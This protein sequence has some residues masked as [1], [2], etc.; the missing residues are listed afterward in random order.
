M[1]KFI[2]HIIN[3]FGYDIINVNKEIKNVNF[4]DLL[5]DKIAK[6]P[7]I[8]DV[9]GNKGQSISRFK[10]IFRKP[11][12]HSFEPIKRE[13]DFMKKK[14]EQDKNVYLNNFAIGD[15]Q[16]YKSFNITAGTGNSSF[17]LIKQ[18]TKWLTV[19]SKQFNTDKENYIVNKE[20]VKVDT[21]DNYC[22]EKNIDFIDL[23]KIDTQGYEDKVLKGSLETIKKNKIGII[24]TEIMFDDV[25]NKHF[26]FSDIEK[27]LIP[28]N[29]RMVG[30]NLI[31]NNLFSGL[32][33]FADVMYFNKNYYK[34]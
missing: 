16:E 1:K 20:K 8:F 18:D 5:R 13:Y 17:N 30:I 15:T 28:N 3:R 12:I 33:F 31:N 6:D 29:F 21:I 24:L 32:V 23:L 10:N 34:I 26:S 19:R 2:K 27:F 11:T 7:L 9:G 4:D 22:E 14:Y 25:Y